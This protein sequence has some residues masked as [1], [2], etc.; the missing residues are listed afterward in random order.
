MYGKL[1]KVRIRFQLVQQ[2]PIWVDQVDGNP[3]KTK[4]GKAFSLPRRVRASVKELVKRSKW[5]GKLLSRK[6]YYIESIEG[7]QG[8]SWPL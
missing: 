8:V 3:S 1:L 4:G 7:M 6:R 5:P 2:L